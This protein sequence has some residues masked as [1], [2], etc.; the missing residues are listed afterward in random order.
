MRSVALA[1]ACGLLASMTGSAVAG[2]LVINM[3][4]EYS[5]AAQPNGAAPWARATFTDTGA[6]LVRL[7]LECLLND[8]GERMARAGG[9][10]NNPQGWA[11]NLDPALNPDNLTFTHVS[12][13][14][15]TGIF[16]GA[17][18]FQAAA[19]RW[20]D[21]L[22]QWGNAGLTQGDTVV[23][24][25]TVSS[26]TLNAQSFAYVTTNGPVGQTG[27]YS[28]VHVQSITNPSG[29][30]GSSGWIGGSLGNP[31][32]PL[33]SAGIMSLAAIGGLAARRRRALA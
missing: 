9:G 5:G 18:E 30:Q 26:G 11:F 2:Q 23:Y 19:D 31:V 1:A 4:H 33:P 6:G 25:L 28:A 12:G 17:N 24:D 8:P 32:I 7:T 14:V 29:G 20:F 3:D 10:P 16:T 13:D 15:A 21:F 22:F 27:N